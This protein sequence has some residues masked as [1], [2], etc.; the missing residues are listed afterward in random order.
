MDQLT[1]FAGEESTEMIIP[2]DVISPLESNKSLKSKAFREVQERWRDYVTSIQDTFGC[3]WFEA[4]KLL[5]KH[6]DE[7]IPIRLCLE[8]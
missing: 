1:L 5:T 3:S 8:G 6:R 4:S 2:K 7:Q